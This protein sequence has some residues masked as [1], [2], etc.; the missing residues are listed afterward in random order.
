MHIFC[1]TMGLQSLPNERMGYI[2][3]IQ[4]YEYGHLAWG[5]VSSE[6]DII[7]VARVHK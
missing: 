4:V 2:W 1:I 5:Y 7:V 6:K 3:N